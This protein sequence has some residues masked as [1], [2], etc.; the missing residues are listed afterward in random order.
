MRTFTAIVGILLTASSAWAQTPGILQIKVLDG[1][2]AI[3]NI[4]NKTGQMITVEVRD[5]NSQLVRGAEVTF[6]TP[7]IGAGGTYANGTRTMTATTD[8]N[9]VAQ[10][11]TLKPNPSEGRFTITIRAR[12]GTREG[13]TAANQTNT[14]AAV[15]GGTS[16]GANANPVTVITVGGVS[17]GAPR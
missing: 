6:T 5:E 11:E 4:R 2:G 13:M 17:V 3:N 15:S 8:A 7:A 1:D 16:R 14:M 12:Q 9:G 10:S